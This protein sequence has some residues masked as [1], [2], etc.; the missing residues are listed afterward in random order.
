MQHILILWVTINWFHNLAV[1]TLALLFVFSLS[2]CE[3]R[4][5]GLA[6]ESVDAYRVAPLSNSVANG[7]GFIRGMTTAGSPWELKTKWTNGNVWDRD[8]VDGDVTWFGNDHLYFD[9]PGIAISYFTGHGIT[10]HGCSGIAC[11]TTNACTTPVAGA[12]LPGTCRFSPFDN[13]QC[14]YLVDRAAVTSGNFDANGGIVNYT[15]G[16][17]RWGES[18]TS[19]AWAGAGTNGGTNLVVLDIS[20]GILPTFW[21]Q[22]L[23]NA[24]AGVH[25]IATLMTG[26]GDTANVADRGSTFAR[27]WAANP[28]GNVAQAWLDTMS[29]LPKE[30][31]MACGNEGGHGF[32]GCGC[33]IVVAMDNTAQSAA[34]K[35]SEDW[36]DLRSDN[37]D[38]RGNDWYSARWQCNYTLS[39]TGASAWELP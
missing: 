3:P 33:H 38:A 4:S 37:R 24:S 22:T 32:N 13:P 23:R 31:G 1:A 8:L 9:Q 34:S 19:G 6:V 20:H 26:G 10:A 11:S 28:N 17:V 36:I 16:Q 21:Y 14:C 7:D 29:T 27:M 2:G 12:R 15:G 18:A 30:E 25:M 5:Y 35:M 39:S